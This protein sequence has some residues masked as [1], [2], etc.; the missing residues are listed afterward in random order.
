MA[1]YIVTSP[2]K[3]GGK[4]HEVGSKVDM[5]VDQAKALMAA[6]VVEADRKAA[7][8]EKTEGGKTGSDLVDTATDGAG[9]GAGDGDGGEG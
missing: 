2:L 8:T 5:P 1:R 4:R 7:P 6:G 9:T 3:H